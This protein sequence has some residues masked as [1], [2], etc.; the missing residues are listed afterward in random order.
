MVTPA[1]ETAVKLWTLLASMEMGNVEGKAVPLVEK[2][3]FFVSDL[4]EKFTDF[5]TAILPDEVK[6]TVQIDIEEY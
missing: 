5:A 3:Q 4:A 6:N 1:Y 2:F